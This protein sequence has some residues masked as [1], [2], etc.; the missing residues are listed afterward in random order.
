MVPLGARS[1]FLG[2]LSTVFSYTSRSLSTTR[3]Q[4]QDMMAGVVMALSHMVE[5]PITHLVHAGV[6]A[7]FSPTQFLFSRL[8]PL[9]LNSKC[10]CAH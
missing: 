6:F 5:G 9:C 8:A 4:A 3:S 1:G 10:I 2:N 7:S